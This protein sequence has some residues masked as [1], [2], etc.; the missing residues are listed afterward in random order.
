MRVR[1]YITEKK[2]L[3]FFLKSERFLVFFFKLKRDPWIFLFLRFAFSFCCFCFYYAV[4]VQFKK[5]WV[6]FWM[7]SNIV[8]NALIK[9]LQ[10]FNLVGE[11]FKR[12]QDHN[13]RQKDDI[14]KMCVKDKFSLMYNY[15]CNYCQNNSS[16]LLCC[17]KQ[18]AITKHGTSM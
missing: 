7:K 14:A 9:L 15:R 12:K 17:M 3:T 1:G 16:N 2:K 4:Y 11:I 18:L 6:V 5:R 13:K 10:N 8:W